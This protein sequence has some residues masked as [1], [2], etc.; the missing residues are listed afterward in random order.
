MEHSTRTISP[1]HVDPESQ[2][3]SLML[4]AALQ[5]AK[6]GFHV[7]PLHSVN[8]SGLCTCLN[9][10]CTSNAKHPLLRHGFK[11]ASSDP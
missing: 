3:R 1:C 9:S 5:Y 8:D 11:D 4:L 6:Q 2:S 7:L 10:S